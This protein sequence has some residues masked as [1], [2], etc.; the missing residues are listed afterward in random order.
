[1]MQYKHENGCGCGLTQITLD[2]IDDTFT[3]SVY[4]RW[5]GSEKIDI[6]L[7][8]FVKNNNNNMKTLYVNTLTNK[9]ND[10]IIELTHSYN[11]HDID[12]EL[13]FRFIDMNQNT[14]F[15]IHDN[16]SGVVYAG[17][18]YFNQ[19]SMFDKSCDKECNKCNKCF[20]YDSILIGCVGGLFNEYDSNSKYTKY[21]NILKYNLMRKKE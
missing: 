18:G 17:G 19:C 2:F 15:D 3:L 9:E 21:A 7:N 4:S 16:V 13:A 20:T 12:S 10:E 14:L 5:M 8:G 11:S 6:V 1:M